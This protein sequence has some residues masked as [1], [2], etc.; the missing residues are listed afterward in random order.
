[1]LSNGLNLKCIGIYGEAVNILPAATHHSSK[2]LRKKQPHFD[3]QRP[4]ESLHVQQTLLT[5]AGPKPAL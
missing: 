1:M 3:M 5:V 2:G 4:A